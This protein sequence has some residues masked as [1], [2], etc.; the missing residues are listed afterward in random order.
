[1]GDQE[2]NGLGYVTY[3]LRKYSS[4]D[5]LLLAISVICWCTMEDSPG[6]PA[7]EGGGI[8]PPPAVAYPL[9]GNVPAL[10]SARPPDCMYAPAESIECVFLALLLVLFWWLWL[11]FELDWEFELDRPGPEEEYEGMPS[12][13]SRFNLAALASAKSGR[14]GGLL[15]SVK[16]L[17][18]AEEED[19]EEW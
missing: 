7:A 3:A 1:M 17:L 5:I 12:V 9:T 18:L 19:D 16:T 11:W 15:L 13:V 14:A 6:R 4:V 10:F 8:M 2:P